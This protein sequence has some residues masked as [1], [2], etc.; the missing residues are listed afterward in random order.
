[1]FDS[2]SDVYAAPWSGYSD[3]STDTTT[4]SSPATEILPKANGRILI[5]GGG[6]NLGELL[7]SLSVHT[8]WGSDRASSS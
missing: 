1:M 3:T 2:D 6:G 4:L 7:R 5:T 8:R